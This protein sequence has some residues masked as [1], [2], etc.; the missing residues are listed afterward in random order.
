LVLV[1]LTIPETYRPVLV[2]KAEGVRRETRDNRYYALMEVNKP[3]IRRWLYNTL[4]MPFKILFLEPM[5]I[6]III[7]QSISDYASPSLH[8]C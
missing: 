8:D 7:Y 1:F 4:T 2:R 3:N 5:L 6:A